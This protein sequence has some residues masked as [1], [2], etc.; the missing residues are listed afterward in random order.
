MIGIILGYGLICIVNFIVKDE[1]LFVFSCK[2]LIIFINENGNVSFSVFDLID[3]Y[4]DNCFLIF[5]LLMVDYNGFSY[6]CI[7]NG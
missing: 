1:V 3:F 7:F 5:V 2:N 4:L 6:D